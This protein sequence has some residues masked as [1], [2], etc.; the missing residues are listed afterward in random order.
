MSGPLS[1]LDRIHEQPTEV[2]AE[3]LL[4]ESLTRLWFLNDAMRQMQGEAHIHVRHLVVM[5]QVLCQRLCAQWQSASVRPV[6]V[7]LCG[8]G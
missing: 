6:A 2:V 1:H 3:P 8:G 5:E 7:C 4:R